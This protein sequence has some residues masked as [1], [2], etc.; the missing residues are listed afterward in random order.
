MEAVYCDGISVL[1][2]VA[3]KSSGLE[4]LKN[5]TKGAKGPKY[6]ESLTKTTGWIASNSSVL[7]AAT[8]LFV[9]HWQN[10]HGFPKFRKHPKIRNGSSFFVRNNCCTKLCNFG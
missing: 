5:L 10:N 3:T 8:V 6:F 9:N 4:S 2:E 1:V 7:R